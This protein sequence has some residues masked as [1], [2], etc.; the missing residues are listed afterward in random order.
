MKK[1]VITIMMALAICL[2][3][4]LPAYA[5]GQNIRLVD[6]AE[7]LDITE[8][9]DILNEL[10]IISQ[11][12]QVDLVIVTADS[13]GSKTPEQFADDFFDYNSYGY[14]HN[15][16]GILLLINMDGRDWHISTSGYGQTAITDDA[17]NHISEEIESDLTDSNYAKAFRTYVKLCDEMITSARNG[18]PY[19]APFNILSAVLIS[20]VIGFVIAL[21]VTAVMKGQLK[22]I[23]SQYG[24]TDY[25]KAGSLNISEA[26]DMFLY[27][28]I[29]RRPKPQNNSSSGSH[30][31]S[32]GRSH[33]GGGGK[34]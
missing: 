8:Y 27:R 1:R 32:S 9:A 28:N 13:I 15:R 19:K 16:D 6:N 33:G 14:G 4:A 2:S 12:H 5:A 20:L 24:A 3:I 17:L 23:R 22:T 34:F 7:L 21:I 10:N 25:V 31:S 11:E 18:H 30:R 26:R 29:T